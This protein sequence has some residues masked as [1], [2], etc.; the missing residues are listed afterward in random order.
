MSETTHFEYWNGI[1]PSAFLDGDRE[2]PM[3]RKAA[4]LIAAAA[5]QSVHPLRMLEIGFGNG[6]DYAAHLSKIPNLVYHGID[7]SEALTAYCRSQ[8][9]GVD[10]RHLTLSR[11]RAGRKR[12]DV[13]Y[14]KAV[15]EHQKDFE[16]P[17]THMLRVTG[18]LALV[19]WYLPP[20]ETV[21]HSYNPTKQMHYNRYEQAAVL[22]LI[23]QQNF[24]CTIH[25]VEGSTNELYELRRV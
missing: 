1:E 17:L 3:R 13:T 16:D 11:V 15:F 6:I 19:N 24:S 5:M 22:R 12:Y 4:E 8:Y 21:E 10:F 23:T 25:R 7:G 18:A 2:N 9:P 20:G 14:A